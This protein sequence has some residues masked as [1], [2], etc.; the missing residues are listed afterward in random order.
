MRRDFRV[1]LFVKP[2]VLGRVKTRLAASLGQ[3]AALAIH[4]AMLRDAGAA[5]SATKAPVIVQYAPEGSEDSLRELLGP[6]FVYA[7][8]KGADLGER[9]AGAIAETF[10]A[11][12]E[13]AVLV[14]GDAPE[15]SVEIIEAARLALCQ[16][17]AG[18]VLGPA[19]DGGYYMIGFTARA[20]TREAFEGVAFGGP[21]VFD[22]TR[23]KLREAGIDPALAPMLRDVDE[24]SD[25]QALA[26]KREMFAQ[27]GAR[28]A[29]ILEQFAPL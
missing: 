11:G 28:I 27:K 10:A 24:L 20:F 16:G 2:P 5:L 21:T 29:A 8:Q 26:R 9:M 22:A 25:L 7:P 19:E 14:G 23:R 17:P 1:I 15:L 3:D 4:T 13:A 6:D 18:A 12:F